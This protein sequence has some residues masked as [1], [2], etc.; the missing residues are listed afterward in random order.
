MDYF[1]YPALS[2]SMIKFLLNAKQDDEEKAYWNRAFDKGSLVDFLTTENGDFNK[3][4]K[5]VSHVHPPANTTQAWKYNNALINQV[6]DWSN[7]V[8]DY[9]QAFVDA[10]IKSPRLSGFKAPSK[11]EF[12]ENFDYSWLKFYTEKQQLLKEGICVVLEEDVEEA[13]RVC[14]KLVD[15]EAPN[16]CKYFVNIPG[17]YETKGQVEIYGTLE[18]C[19]VKIKI[20]RVCFD[21]INKTVQLVDVK[22]TID[23][24][25]NFENAMDMFKYYIQAEFYKEVFEKGNIHYCNYDLSDYQDFTVLKDFVFVVLPKSD[26]KPLAFKYRTE[27]EK[28]LKTIY[29]AVEMYKAMD[30]NGLRKTKQAYFEWLATQVGEIPLREKE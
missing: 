23:F 18:E 12:I 26:S 25:S 10:E 14:L 2:N 30:E 15:V 19:P 6:K 27:Q 28:H 7:P 13:K 17:V 21:M 29:E 1:S 20:D 22:T 11:E 4:F 24:S 5:V 3:F 16:V 8:F 9:E